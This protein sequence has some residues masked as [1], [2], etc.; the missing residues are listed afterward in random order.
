MIAASS[1]IAP[2]LF[3]DGEFIDEELLDSAGRKTS[4]ILNPATGERLA[5]LPYASS[6]DLD[7]ALAAAARTFPVWKRTPAND[8]SKILRA[9]AALMRE[10]VQSIAHGMTL[11]QGKP[12]AE[13][14]GEVIASAEILEWYAEE[15]RR[16]YGRVVPG[17]SPDARHYVV[18]EAIGPVAA[19]TPWN[20]PGLLSARKIGGSLAAGCT[21]IIKPAEETP[22]TTLA[23]AQAL[24]DAGLPAGVLNVVFGNPDEISRYLI[25]SPV[26]RKVS[27][28]GSTVVGKLLAKRAAEGVKAI[29]LE[30]GGHAPVI[31]FEDADL[32]RAIPV[33]MGLKFRNA[34]QVC[35]SP[36]RFF[37]HSAIFDRFIALAGAFAGS[38]VMGD[39]LDASTRMGP[40]ANSRRVEAMQRL[41]ADAVDK[42]ATITSGG[43]QLERPGNYWPPTV[44]ANVPDHAAIMSEEPFGPVV[45]A[46][47]FSTFD[48]VIERANSV[49][50][51]L[52][53]YVFT[54][55]LATATR[56]SEMIEAGMVSINGGAIS[57]AEIPFG[58]VKESGYG[59]EGG[60]EGLDAYLVTK[61]IA[62]GA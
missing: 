52:A 59:S 54:S 12:L 15:S 44:L 21:C 32:E 45:A 49:P 48:E 26:I 60:I 33:I 57:L 3:I 7:R 17:R 31:V 30:L 6:A 62:V 13:S 14:V 50:F 61:S 53:S 1:Y 43:A 42:G 10:R 47:P 11:E 2:R 40:M 39:G 23:I 9:A 34:G 56:A 27:F 29:S 28:T 20:F 5:D 19:F 41:V 58:G 25:A 22:A 37:V 46:A 36:T 51:G 38:L 35:V 24:A 18:R 8:R 4:P 16:A 55:S